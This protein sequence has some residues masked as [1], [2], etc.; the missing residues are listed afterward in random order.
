LRT[1]MN[2]ILSMVIMLVTLL[3]A[4][5]VH[6]FCHAWMADRLGDPTARHLGR[7]SLNPIVHLDPLG[8][9][10]MLMAIF[11]GIGIGWG[12]PV[13][14]DTRRLR[15]NPMVGAGLVSL[16]GPASNLVSAFALAVLAWWTR[17]VLLGTGVGAEILFMLFFFGA[18]MNTSLA[19]F[20]LIPLPP[21][22]GFGVLMGV[23]AALQRPW[24]YRWSVQLARFGRQGAMW[25]FLLI[26]ADWFLA[27][28]GF[29]L[30]GTYL[31]TP[32]MWVEALIF[33]G[34]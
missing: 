6:E 17:T 10:M 28:Y 4:L 13:P 23:M 20:N 19:F 7:V 18:L 5:T 27:R 34:M 26:A 12:K 25:L 29:S 30:L 11:S 15:P 2:Q 21:L 24:A 31:R 22:D 14:I 9:I 33:G 32:M 1:Y 16:A 8:S 3:F